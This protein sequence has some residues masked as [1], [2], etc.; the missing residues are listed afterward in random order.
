MKVISLLIAAFLAC[1]G[2]LILFRAIKD[3]RK[4]YLGEIKSRIYNLK[5]AFFTGVSSSMLFLT[6]IFVVSV[7][8]NE[9]NWTFQGILG[10]LAISVLVGLIV[11]FG[12][13]IGYIIV[14]KY[15]VTLVK[16]VVDDLQE[17]KHN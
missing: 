8:E 7:T 6:L 3:S 9:F 17:D 15:R 14:D 13:Y 5:N 11:F 12:T 10:S 2:L 4:I 1:L 16:K